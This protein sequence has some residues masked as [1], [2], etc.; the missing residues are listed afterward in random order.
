LKDH[1]KNPVRDVRWQGDDEVKS[2]IDKYEVADD[3]DPLLHCVDKDQV[4]VNG[5]AWHV[6]VRTLS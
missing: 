3:F 6:M 4:N 5:F 2:V 1:G